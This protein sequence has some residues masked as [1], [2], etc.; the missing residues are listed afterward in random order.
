MRKSYLWAVVIAGGLGVWMASPYFMPKLTGTPAPQE[1][2]TAELVPLQ[3][4]AFSVRVKE[5]DAVARE[6]V[7]TASGVTAASSSIE[8]RARTTGTV[9]EQKFRQGDVV[10]Q[11]DVL[12]Q[13]DNGTREAQL[14]QAKA[15]L[16]SAQRDYDAS[17][18][19][20][21]G[22]YASNQVLLSNKAKVD[23]AEAGVRAIEA[24]LGYLTIKAT[25]DGVL[26]EKPAEPGTLLAI[27]G[28]CATVS[29]LDPLVV[30]VQLSERDI[31]YVQLGMQ[32]KAKL[33]TGQEAQG[34]V[35]FISKS[36]DLA[37]RTLRV[38][39]EVQNPGVFMSAGVSAQLIAS[40]PAQMAQKIP[41]S[42]IILNDK[43]ETG[44]RVLNADKTT[45][46]QKVMIFNQDTDG[47]WVNGLPNKV[48][49]VTT[50]QDYVNDGEPVEPVIETAE[51]N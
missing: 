28:L 46:F 20:A 5:F 11:G 50:G 8:A 27:G 29:K 31:P 13:L 30:A 38:E 40:L 14:A 48:T 9:L 51:A 21:R 35:T 18:K 10:K 33:A 19:L 34:K 41:G 36:A 45:Q 32:A 1:P 37:T 17:A 47:F 12:C 4:K 23:A 49:L 26:V 3:K 6:A 16:E 7:V 43:G 22:G 15:A 44:V 2:A 42:I 39:L 24:D 25:T